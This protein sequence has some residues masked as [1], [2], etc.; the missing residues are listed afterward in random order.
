MLPAAQV[1]MVQAVQGLAPQGIQLM[2]WATRVAP[3]ATHAASVE[4]Q[5]I[6]LVWRRQTA[7]A[8][9]RRSR[10]TRSFALPPTRRRKTGSRSPGAVRE[11]REIRLGSGA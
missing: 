3:M 11:A 5:K 6:R 8:P 4:A 2:E 7:T 1:Q 9:G 10:L